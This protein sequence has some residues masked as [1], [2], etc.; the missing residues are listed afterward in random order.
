MRVCTMTKDEATAAKVETFKRI[1]AERYD[2]SMG[3]SVFTECYDDQQRVE[4]VKDCD[5][6]EAVIQLMTDVASI[7]D[8]RYENA[9]NER[10]MF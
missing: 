3:W 9:R 7:D 2:R 8:D 6:H 1:A 5:S 4:F 10:H